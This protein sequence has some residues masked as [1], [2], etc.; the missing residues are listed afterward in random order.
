M[1]FSAQ[2][3]SPSK[4]ESSVPVPSSA[5]G[6]KRPH[7]DESDGEKSDEGE[8]VVDEVCSLSLPFPVPILI[9]LSGPSVACWQYLSSSSQ[10][11]PTEIKKRPSLHS[12]LFQK[13]WI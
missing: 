2:V 8:L 12:L 5:S 13:H 11:R 6:V 9:I 1:S 7:E 3:G 10:R 4:H